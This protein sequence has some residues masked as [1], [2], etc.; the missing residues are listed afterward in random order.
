MTDSIWIRLRERLKRSRFR[1]SFKLGK[2]EIDYLRTRGT[3]IIRNHA[4]DFVRQRLAPAA[5]KN[6][7]KQTPMK[8][9]PVF[10]A[11]HATGTCCRSCLGKWHGIA[12][13]REMTSGEIQYVVSVITR[14]IQWKSSS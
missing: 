13:G 12:E 14:W 7:G 10:I 4:F 2:E 8:G 9:H 5:P 3:D 6:D 11:Q 1:S